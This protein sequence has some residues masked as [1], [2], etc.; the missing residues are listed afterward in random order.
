MPKLIL[1]LQVSEQSLLNT[2][3]KH[4]NINL[5]TP[6]PKELL[7]VAMAHYY[8]SLAVRGDD[9]P[10]K[11]K[12]L[13]YLDARQLYPDLQPRSWKEYVEELLAGNVKSPYPGR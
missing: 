11:A 12:Y 4:Q 5:G 9:T 13:G 10:E 8:Y 7:A 1:L 3:S 6:G 2:I